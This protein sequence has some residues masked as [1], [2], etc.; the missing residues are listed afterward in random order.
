[1][2][3]I[4]LYLGVKYEHS[5]LQYTLAT[6]AF[7]LGYTE[8]GHCRGEVEPSLPPPKRLVWDIPSEVRR[9]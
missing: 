4:N 8:D 9:T 6:D 7:H 3:Y 2:K 5:F 1:M